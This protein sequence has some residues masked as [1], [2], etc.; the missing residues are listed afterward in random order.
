MNPKGG[1]GGGELLSLLLLACY[2]LKLGERR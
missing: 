2:N 1:G